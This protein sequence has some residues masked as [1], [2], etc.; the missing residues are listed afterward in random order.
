MLLLMMGSPLTPLS[1]L[2]SRRSDP[3]L[4]EDA[5]LHAV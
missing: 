5:N 3:S 2:A 4:A 1:G